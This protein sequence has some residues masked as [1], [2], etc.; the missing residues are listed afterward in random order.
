MDNQIKEDFSLLAIT[1]VWGAS[2]PLMSVALKS[3]PP[4][5]F[6]SI[7]YLLAGLILAVIFIKK[8]NK[9]NKATIMAGV[10][11]GSSLGVGSILQAVGLLYTTPSKSGFITG[12]NVILVPILLTVGVLSTVPATL[13]EGFKMNINIFAVFAIVFTVIF[14]TIFAYG[15]QNIAQGYTTPTHTAIIFLAEPVFSAIFSVFIGDKLTGRTL[16]GCLL[17]LAGMF[18]VNIKLE[19][20]GETI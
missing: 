5:T 1:V 14:C 6:I 15:V 12:L 16:V 10:V 17:I 20:K 11:I 4:Y 2:F 19:R 9:L 7:R 3:V 13:I 8:F 18:I